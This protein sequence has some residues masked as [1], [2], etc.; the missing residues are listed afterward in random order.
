MRSTFE[1]ETPTGETLLKIQEKIKGEKYLQLRYGV[2][3]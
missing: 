3:V 1:L 2:A